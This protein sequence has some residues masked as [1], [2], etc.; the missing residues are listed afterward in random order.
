MPTIIEIKTSTCG[1]PGYGKYQ[2]ATYW[3]LL[4]RNPH[5][6]TPGLKMDENHAYWIGKKKLVSVTGI[7]RATLV[8]WNITDPCYRDRGIWVHKQLVDYDKS[9]NMNK[10]QIF[11]DWA[12]RLPFDLK[13]SGIFYRDCVLGYLQFLEDY[14]FEGKEIMNEVPLACEKLRIAGTL[15]KIVIDGETKIKAYVLLL[16]SS[17]YKA[18]EIKPKDQK[19]LFEKFKACKIV[20]QERNGRII[21]AEEKERYFSELQQI[22]DGKNVRRNLKKFL[23]VNK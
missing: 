17:N 15:D 18:I 11:C 9:F 7:L 6:K 5:M 12:K 13:K 4:K 1:D 20:N 21:L 22:A 19:L 2:I 10:K 14:G 16:G 3:E 23:E 8:N